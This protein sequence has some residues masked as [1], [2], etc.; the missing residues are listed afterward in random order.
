MKTISLNHHWQFKLGF[1]AN[2]LKGFQGE[3]VSIPHSNTILPKQYLDQNAYQFISSYQKHIH[4]KKEADKR[5]FLQFDGIMNQSKIYINETMI[6]EQV[7]GYTKTKIEITEHM[8]DDSF[9]LTV[10]VNS[11][12]DANHHPYGNVIDFLTYGGIYREVFLHMTEKD[13]F[14]YVHINGNKD[15][16]HIK[17]YPNSQSN[18]EHD[19][20]FV[21]KEQDNEVMRMTEKKYLTQHFNLENTHSLKLWDIDN[22]NLYQLQIYIDQVLSYETTFGIREVHVSKDGFY[23]NGKKVFLRGLNRHQSFPY[24]GYAMPKSAQIED[25]DILKYELQVNMVRSSHYPPSKHFLNRCDE[26]GLL[27]FTELPGWQHIGDQQWKDHAVDFLESMTN[28]DYNHPS[29][30]I[31]GTRINESNDDNVFYQKTQ[32]VFKSIDTSRPSGGVRYIAKSNKLEDIYTVNDFTHRGNNKGLANKKHMTHPNNPYLV[33]E[34]NGHMFPTKSFDDEKHR[35]DHAK[36]HFSV[37]NDAYKMKGLM[38]AIGWCMFDYHTHKEF[39][40]NDHVCYHGVLDMNRNSKYA[41]SVYASQGEKPYMSVLNMM[42]IGD[43][44]NGELKEV[45]VATNCDY[46]N[47]YKNDAFI[48]SYHRDKKIYPFLPYPP[49]VIKDLIGNQIHENERFSNKDAS[50]IKKA[51]LKTLNNDLKMSLKTKLVL[52]YMLIKYKM[53]KEEAYAL[54]TR[55]VGGW[56]EKAKVYRFEGIK[57]EKIVATTHKGFNDDYELL[58]TSSKKELLIEQTYDVAKITVELKNKLEMRAFYSSDVIHI[59]SNDAIELIGPSQIALQGGI[60][61][62]WVKT[63]KPGKA[64]VTISSLRYQTQTIDLYV[65]Q[66]K[67]VSHI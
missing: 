8:P 20:L 49:I 62:F 1:D 61:S 14:D 65:K 28:H 21:I 2:D 50:R 17:A 43:L 31:V 19:L 15:R 42:H 27:V 51:L 24:V 37:L 23:L 22:P 64:Y 4:M 9:I 13:T 55:Y 59:E 57:D 34:F 16:L 41:K 32:D 54:Y 58:I 39:G 44:A 47:V 63:V 10:V 60:Q 3:G 40:S 67:N 38:G 45:V 7:G 48:G 52:L 36:R 6:K 25:A 26:I 12:E 30:V 53:P 35:I 11:K 18:K 33:T 29:I 56:G 66:A 46:I 5:Y